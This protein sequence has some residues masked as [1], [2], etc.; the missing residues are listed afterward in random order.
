MMN[1]REINCLVVMSTT[2]SEYAAGH[3]ASR[4]VAESFK[5]FYC[6]NAAVAV[7]ANESVYYCKPAGFHN[8]K[9][10]A[11]GGIYAESIEF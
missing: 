6:H 7:L 8:D 1:G 11:E 10:T 5:F 4:Q 2:E 3:D 9:G